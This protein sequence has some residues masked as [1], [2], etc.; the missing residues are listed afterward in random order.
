MTDRFQTLRSIVNL[1]PYTMVATAAMVL[2]ELRTGDKIL[3][4]W[5]LACGV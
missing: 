1:C 3:E 4:F 5:G 2:Q